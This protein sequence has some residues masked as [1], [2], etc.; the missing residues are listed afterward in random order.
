ME[1]D[2]QFSD[3]A[4]GVISNH[5][6][7]HFDQF[8]L[9]YLLELGVKQVVYLGPLAAP[10]DPDRVIELMNTLPM[11]WVYGKIDVR[12]R[13][14]VSSEFPAGDAELL[15]HGILFRYFVPSSHGN[16]L[17]RLWDFWWPEDRRRAT[18][19]LAALLVRRSETRV[20]VLGSG[21]DFEH[22]TFDV[23][24]GVMTLREKDEPGPGKHFLGSVD[25]EQGCTHIIVHPA[26]RAHR[27][28]V[29]DPQMNRMV[30]FKK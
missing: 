28:S 11:K 24:R 2:A 9:Q 8:Q 21:F 4:V 6:D 29:V 27:C 16:E 7:H 14:S 22:W 20:V 12:E 17:L 30:I 25:L 19:T 10:D 13:D 1:R 18:L 26:S 5:G 15:S 23:D 3:K